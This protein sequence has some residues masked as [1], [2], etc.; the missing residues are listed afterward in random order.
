M[1][2]EIE[3]IETKAVEPNVTLEFT[4]NDVNLVLAALQELPHKIADPMIRKI[5]EQAQAQLGS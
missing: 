3:T 1:E 2:D 5:M 4:V